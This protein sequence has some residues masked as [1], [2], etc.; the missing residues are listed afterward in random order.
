MFPWNWVN[1]LWATKREDVRLIVHAISFQDY[2]PIWSW[3]TN[4]TDRRWTERWTDNV[5]L[6]DRALLYRPSA[7]CG[8]RTIIQ[9]ARNYL[10][11]GYSVDCCEIKRT[12]LRSQTFAGRD[13]LS[14][15]CDASETVSWLSFRRSVT[16]QPHFV[17]LDSCRYWLVIDSKIQTNIQRRCMSL[18]T[19]MNARRNASS[20]QLIIFFNLSLCSGCNVK[21]RK[22][23]C[24]QEWTHAFCL[25]IYRWSFVLFCFVLFII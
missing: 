1:G 3:S 14:D 4:V 8:N 10:Q 18:Q 7:S 23:K 19:W 6:Q 13:M 20:Q 9:T 12:N 21:L 5:R 15:D 17:L 25:Y 2:Q 11:W 16:S 22:T 24:R